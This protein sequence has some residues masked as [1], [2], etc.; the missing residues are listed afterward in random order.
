MKWRRWHKLYL[1][2]MTRRNQGCIVYILARH[3]PDL[4]RSISGSARSRNQTRRFFYYYFYCR[5]KRNCQTSSHSR[6]SC[7]E[8]SVFIHIAIRRSIEN[9]HHFLCASISRYFATV[10]H[11]VL[12]SPAESSH[13]VSWRLFT[14]AATGDTCDVLSFKKVITS[15]WS[16]NESGII[17]TKGMQHDWT[18][19]ETLEQVPTYWVSDRILVWQFSCF[20]S[21]VVVSLVWRW[22]T[23]TSNLY[24]GRVLMSIKRYEKTS[25]SSMWKL[26]SWQSA[27][28]LQW[29]AHGNNIRAR[30]ENPRHHLLN[31]LWLSTLSPS[32]NHIRLD[33]T[34]FWMLR[35]SNLVITTAVE[36]FTL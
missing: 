33:H 11:R 24:V 30:N 22:A 12:A 34:T 27:N 6:N 32:T 14:T 7:S 9:I 10:N 17:E 29:T 8:R 1:F 4:Q 26:F 23:R 16:E 19:I 21:L 2:L 35:Q 15:F 3:L 18:R 13:K 31:L 25:W 5:A 20:F 28:V 36:V